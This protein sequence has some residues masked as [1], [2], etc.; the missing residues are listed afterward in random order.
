M[1]KVI[2]FPIQA[3]VGETDVRSEVRA[4]KD[5]IRII[6][7]YRADADVDF[8][9]TGLELRVQQILDEQAEVVK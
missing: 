8:A 4:L 9:V 5:A 2:Q 3:K 1:G 7:P 6:M